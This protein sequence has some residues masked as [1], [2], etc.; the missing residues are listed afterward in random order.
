MN[1]TIYLKMIGRNVDPSARIT[2]PK[3]DRRL[4]RW[5]FVD[6]DFIQEN[7]KRKSGKESDPSSHFYFLF[8]LRRGILP[9][10]LKW[11]TSL[12][13]FSYFILFYF[14]LLREGPSSLSYLKWP[15]GHLLNGRVAL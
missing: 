12:R 3:T 15:H 1:L 11:H 4:D 7:L 13:P 2:F 8:F 6:R 9:L 14:F 5:I 10:L